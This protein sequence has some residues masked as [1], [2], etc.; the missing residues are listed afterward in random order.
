MTS[1]Y[2][3]SMN[4]WISPFCI[5]RSLFTRFKYLINEAANKSAREDLSVHVPWRHCVLLF[6]ACVLKMFNLFLECSK[7]CTIVH[8]ANIAL[9]LVTKNLPGVMFLS[10]RGG[11]CLVW[12]QI[13]SEDTLSGSDIWMSQ[14]EKSQ[15]SQRFIVNTTV[16]E[17]ASGSLCR[18][19][20]VK[21]NL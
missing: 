4:R 5:R 12:I 9:W 15:N 8:I 1:Y 6:P 14:Q 7:F 13:F 17:N 21:S 20:N 11:F 3:L 18:K 2:R 10:I 16:L 19:S